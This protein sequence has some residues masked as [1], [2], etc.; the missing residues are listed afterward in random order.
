MIM[1]L[2][3]LDKNFNILK[4][5]RFVNLQWI[6]RY[7]EPGEFSVQV[8]EGEYNAA[9]EY[10]YT[11]ERPELG[12][13]QRREHVA[14]YDGKV[15]QLS[16]YFYEYKLNDKITFPRYN[17]NGNIETIARDMVSRYKSDIPLLRLGN[18]AGIGT[19]ITKQSTGDGLAKVLFEMLA[20]QEMSYRTRY[21][22]LNNIMYFEVW[23]GRDR[24]QDQS[25]NSFATFSETF[26]NMQ[27]VNIILDNSAYKNYAVVIGNGV[28]EDGNQIEVD[29]DLRSSSAEYKQIIYVDQTSMYYDSSQ[30]T[31]AEYKE[32][33][34]QAGIEALEETRVITNVTFDTVK[35]RLDYMKDYDLGDKCDII[36]DSIKQSFTVRIIE[37]DELFKEGV[38]TIT[39][40][41]G[42]QLPTIYSKAR[43]K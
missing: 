31:L 41:F 21:D 39:L 24:T 32:Q 14:T 10:I 4:Y 5:F 19:S 7:Y 16:G 17:G 6:R 8:P 38:H 25:V 1:E 33:L 29:V 36:L 34:R 11:N 37:V 28:Y 43:R 2:V 12:M 42:N 26:K 13:I 27:N 9:A 3:Y 18:I 15:M 23:K 30:Q 20:T 35:G 22:Y 40:Q